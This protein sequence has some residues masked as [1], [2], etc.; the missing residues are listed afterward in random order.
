MRPLAPLAHYAESA[1]L[2]TDVKVH[3]VGI[4]AGGTF[5]NFMTQVQPSKALRAGK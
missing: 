2:H 4:W 3:Q 5:S 1:Q